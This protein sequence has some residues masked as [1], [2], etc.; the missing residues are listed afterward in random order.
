MYTSL[1]GRIFSLV[2]NIDIF[3]DILWYISIE[4]INKT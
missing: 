3:I 4:K 1:N 2:T